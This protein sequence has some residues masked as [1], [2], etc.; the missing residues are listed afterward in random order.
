MTDSDFAA[1]VGCTLDEVARF[2][3]DKRR[4]LEALAPVVDEVMLYDAGLGPLPAGVIVCR[5]KGR[6]AQ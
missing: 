4:Q 6:R 2:P 3:A 5:A 1:V